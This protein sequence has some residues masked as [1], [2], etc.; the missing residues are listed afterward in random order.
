MKNPLDE[1]VQAAYVDL[2]ND[3]GRDD[4][5]L[6]HRSW[7]ARENFIACSDMLSHL[8]RG[9]ISPIPANWNVSP[10]GCLKVGF[11]SL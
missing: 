2:G 9:W 10:L 8:E 11:F 5:E 7:R 3:L 6:W 4:E 1:D